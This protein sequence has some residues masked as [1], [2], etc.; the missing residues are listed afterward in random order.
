MTRAAALAM[1]LLLAGLAYAH[2]EAAVEWP[3]Y[4][5]DQAGTKYSPLADV[6]RGNVGRLRV[7]WEWKTGEVAKP[8]FG[9]RPGMFQNTPL[10]IGGVLYVSTPYNRV[11]ALDA[12]TGAEIWSF[13]PETYRDGQPPNGTGYVHRGLAAWR[14]GSQLR[15]FLNTRYRLICL[16]AATGKPVTAF[17][18]QG[19]VDLSQGLVW[20]I[21]KLHYT[22]TSPPVV[23]RDL[24]ILGNGVGD[25]LTYRHD[26]PGDVRAFDARTGKLV[27][28][29]HTIPQAGEVGNE[30]W[31]ESSWRF[32]GHTN[33]WAPMTLDEARGL[34]Y[35]PVSTPSNDFYGGRRPGANLFAESLVC[36]DATTG[37]RKWHFQ[38]VRHG[39]W[40][41]DLASPPNLVTITVGGRTIDAVVQLTKQSLVFVFDRATGEPVWPIEERAVPQSDVPGERTWATQP[42]PSKPPPLTPLGVSLEDAFDLSPALRAQAQAE[43]KKYRLGPLYTPPSLEGTLMRPGIIGGANWG[44]AS[45]DAGS[46]RLYVK[47]SNLPNLLRIIRPD[48]SEKNPLASEVDAQWTGDLRNM[49]ATFAE[50]VP[51]T[52]PPYAHLTAIDLQQGTIAWQVPFGDWPALREHP[53]LKGVAFPDRLGATGPMGTLATAGG[54]VFAAGGD[55]SFYAFDADDGREL[56]HVP[57]E[58]RGTSTPMTYRSARGR[59]MIALATG[60]GDNTALVAF[61]LGDASPSVR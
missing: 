32:T 55:T 22:N 20:A 44:G 36:L 26:P 7:A 38:I 21:N 58:R 51:L 43:M 59:Q 6:N 57:L 45:F 28:T 53:A 17:G 29:F 15:L 18:D 30:T 9:T 14:D 49:S 2:Q 47:T 5:G 54:L 3:V 61:A 52:K 16:D 19:V 12:D 31:G 35:L 39:V 46:G 37:Q 56:W 41:Y 13:D 24:V 48:R 10:M 60:S 8:E 34:L 27:W 11:V 50:G 1:I 33:V 23:Y 25:R 40:D 4:G 42:F